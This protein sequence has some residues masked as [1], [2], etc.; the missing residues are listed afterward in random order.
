MIRSRS[1]HLLISLAST[2]L[3][4][5]R[6]HAIEPPLRVEVRVTITTSGA[7]F[8]AGTYLT[9]SALG[10]SQY[11]IVDAP[12]DANGNAV[13]IGEFPA[14]A[15]SVIVYIPTIMHWGQPEQLT[16][17]N[18]AAKLADQAFS[19]PPAKFIT[20]QPAQE[21][22]V[23]TF[24]V[25]DAITV[26][27]RAVDDQGQPL[28]VGADRGGMT[29]LR[30]NPAGRDGIFEVYGV[31]KGQGSVLFLST[32]QPEQTVIWLT[33]AQTDADLD[34]GDVI[35]QSATNNATVEIA[36]TGRETVRDD[37]GMQRDYVTLIRED[38]RVTYIFEITEQ[39]GIS[40]APL[41]LY[42]GPPKVQTGRY[43]I[44]PG[45]SV[46][47]ESSLK[48][49][50]LILGGQGVL[51]DAAHVPVIEP[52]A[53]QTTVGSIDLDAVQQAIDGLPG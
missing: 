16:V 4:A 26:T 18:E 25:P 28:L 53:N 40:H 17:K 8:P 24:F 7:P 1:L 11:A 29:N 46:S 37:G 41:G 15:E 47:S 44:V 2:A 32:N 31:P 10:T 3:L 13:L 52:V 12:T 48:A 45:M 6:A 9:M 5:P 30:F 23:A 49:L 51:L 14:D 43:Y 21:I 38:G 36:V 22:Y 35:L 39:G 20:L 27:G 42:P 33:A 34:L 50:R 19:L